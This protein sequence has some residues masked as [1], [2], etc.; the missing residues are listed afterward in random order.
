MNTE[1]SC[2]LVKDC[3]LIYSFFLFWFV[4]VRRALPSQKHVSR[5]SCSSSGNVTD[6]S[7]QLI[8]ANTCFTFVLDLALMTQHY[9][10]TA[11]FDDPTP[12]AGI[13][14]K[15]TNSVGKY[16]GLRHPTQPDGRP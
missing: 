2:S 9:D 5:A 14:S 4:E 1:A 15:Y 10:N 7:W 11:C 8:H 3:T 6:G 16:W 13:V 12:D